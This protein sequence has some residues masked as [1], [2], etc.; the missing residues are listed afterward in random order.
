MAPHLAD[1]ANAMN[2]INPV[3]DRMKLLAFVASDEVIELGAGG[4]NRRNPHVAEALRSFETRG[5]QDNVPALLRAW[6]LAAQWPGSAIVWIHAPQPM[7]LDSTEPLTQA[8]ER[9]GH[10]SPHIFELQ[11]EPGPDRILEKLDGFARVHSMLR[12][13]DL[14]RDLKALFQSWR[15]G[16]Q[17]W[18]MTRT[19]VDSE[20]RGREGG[21]VETDLHLA[22]L[23]AFDEVR[24]LRAAR[25]SDEAVRLA[26]RPELQPT[27]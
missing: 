27:R 25:Q 16:H 12:K 20:S 26:A 11:A 15:A 3:R 23:W 6:N 10:D 14:A 13:G 8:L 22:R 9:A 17:S 1:I 24:R 19:A 18:A 4:T 5:G 7:L 2:T 21:A